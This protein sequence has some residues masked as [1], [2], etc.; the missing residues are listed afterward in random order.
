MTSSVP[1]ARLEKTRGS[2][3]VSYSSGWCMRHLVGEHTQLRMDKDYAALQEEGEGESALS[4][5]HKQHE[6]SIIIV[7]S[8]DRVPGKA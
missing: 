7:R 2:K 8:G 1:E 6:T 5:A 4:G 3:E